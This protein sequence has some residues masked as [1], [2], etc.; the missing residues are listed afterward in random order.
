M[1]DPFFKERLKC[2]V[3]CYAV[4]FFAGFLLNICMLES[5]AVLDEQFQD[6][7]SAIGNA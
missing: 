1:N 7:F 4:E 5:T 6:F 3:N 2:S